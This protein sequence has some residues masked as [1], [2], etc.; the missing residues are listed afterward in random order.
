MFLVVSR[1]IIFIVVKVGATKSDSELDHV[2][3]T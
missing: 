1:K 3:A 2:G